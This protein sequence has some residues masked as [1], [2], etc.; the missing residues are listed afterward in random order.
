MT[1]ICACVVSCSPSPEQLV[2]AAKGDRQRLSDLLKRADNPELRQLVVREVYNLEGAG[3]LAELLGLPDRDA[4]AAVVDMLVSLGPSALPDIYD[5]VLSPDNLA[6]DSQC[7]Q[8]VSSA[9]GE[10][11]LQALPLVLAIM[12]NPVGRSRRS[13]DIWLAESR[14]WSEVTEQALGKIGNPAVASL[15]QLLASDDLH[16]DAQRSVTVIEALA[17]IG[18]LEAQEALLKELRTPLGARPTGFIWKKRIV[19][20]LEGMGWKPTDTADKARFLIFAGIGHPGKLKFEECAQLGPAAAPVL[21]DYIEN[22]T[23][24]TETWLH[25]A[26]A[27]ASIDDPSTQSSLSEICGTIALTKSRSDLRR[28]AISRTTNQAVLA[29]VVLD[30]TKFKLS[31]DEKSLALSRLADHARLVEVVETVKFP[32]LRNKA[33]GKITNV[34]TIIALA[35]EDENWNIRKCAMLRLSALLADSTNLNLEPGP[36]QVAAAFSAIGPKYRTRFMGAI[37]TAAE[38][39]SQ[40]PVVAHLGAITNVQVSVHFDQ[41]RYHKDYH[42][43]LVKREKLTSEFWFASGYSARYTWFRD[44]PAQTTSEHLECRPKANDII[45]DALAVLSLEALQDI[46]THAEDSR[47]Q[48]VASQILARQ[49]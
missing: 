45:G 29:D 37:L 34:S 24:P 17:V 46:A 13:H 1:A 35:V 21:L 36:L 6:D 19:N 38:E 16:Y 48:R 31:R 4:R 49:R 12:Q 28:A 5:G 43:V 7:V 8:D 30:R 15:V 32:E 11:G 9:L 22:V 25:A 10:H 41:Q 44:F 26:D 33:I 27:V 14:F 39:F 2:K 42:I 18:G 3:G 40:N 23:R 20:A 47:C